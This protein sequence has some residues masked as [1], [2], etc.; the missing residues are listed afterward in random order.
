MDGCVD[1][2]TVLNP[3][4]DCNTQV[5]GLYVGKRPVLQGLAPGSVNVTISPASSAVVANSKTTLNATVM[6][7]SEPI[8]AISLTLF[9]SVRTGLGVKATGASG[10]NNGGSEYAVSIGLTPLLD[11]G[12]AF[13]RCVFRVCFR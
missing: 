5:T 11:Q 13:T 6:E 1:S 2:H 8:L 3:A 9:N 4:C 10:R 12:E 7:E